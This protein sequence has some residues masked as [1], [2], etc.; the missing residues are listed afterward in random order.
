M[1]FNFNAHIF[2]WWKR[3]KKH[4]KHNFTDLFL[5][6]YDYDN[7]FD[8]LNDKEFID[9]LAGD[10]KVLLAKIKPRNNSYKRIKQ[11]QIN[12]ISSASTSA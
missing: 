11:N 1:I 5:D 9:L 2:F 8:E 6:E 12:T 10:E 4:S 7:W 3:I